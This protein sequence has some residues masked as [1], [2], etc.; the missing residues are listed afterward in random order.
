MYMYVINSRLCISPKSWP[1]SIDYIWIRSNSTERKK[2][3]NSKNR[4]IKCK[5]RR[6]TDKTEHES[7]CPTRIGET[8]DG[9]IR[10]HLSQYTSQE[11]CKSMRYCGV[12]F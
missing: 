11:T 5:E 10:H 2:E 9:V 7:H 6:Q 4:Q 8:G 3:Q 1:I 12:R